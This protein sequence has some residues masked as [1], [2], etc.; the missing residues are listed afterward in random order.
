MALYPS[1]SPFLSPDGLARCPCGRGRACSWTGGTGSGRRAPQLLCID[2]SSR[3]RS[4]LGAGRGE[5]PARRGPEHGAGVSDAQLLARA[6]ASALLDGAARPE[7]RRSLRQRA[8]PQLGVR[9]P[10]A[11][12]PYGSPTRGA[13]PAVRRAEERHRQASER[14]FPRESDEARAAV[15]TRRGLAAPGGESANL[16]PR[17]F[18]GS[19]AAAARAAM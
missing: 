12:L 10:R 11:G 9:A 6:A 5:L 14:P 18:P 8:G 1:A 15:Q 19:A 4:P 2:A 16:H 13:H 7:S 3:W 17:H